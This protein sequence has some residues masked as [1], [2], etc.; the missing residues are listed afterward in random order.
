MPSVQEILDIAMADPNLTGEE[1]KYLQQ[2]ASPYLAP[3]TPSFQPE[4]LVLD[5]FTQDGRRYITPQEAQANA[6]KNEAL[7]VKSALDVGN[8]LAS[9]FT[10]PEPV[11]DKVQFREKVAEPKIGPDGKVIPNLVNDKIQVTTE[12]G[13]KNR[14]ATLADI[15]GSEVV[16]SGQGVD[17]FGALS[18]GGNMPT[19]PLN[20]DT[21][22]QVALAQNQ[23]RKIRGDFAPSDAVIREGISNP[24]PAVDITN[25]MFRTQPNLPVAIPD[26]TVRD[27][28]AIPD[29]TQAGVVRNQLPP[30]TSD[31]IAQIYQKNGRDRD[32]TKAELIELG[33]TVD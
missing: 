7:R 13:F 11:P 20:R 12:G 26:Q 28:V 21:A 31:I 10:F 3:K 17:P 18:F 30:L 5:S 16:P 32:K 27:V 15:L 24:I 23:A 2:I 33:Y 4:G 6:A 22:V 19:I 1:Q 29:Q 9:R 25:P 14:A 8:A